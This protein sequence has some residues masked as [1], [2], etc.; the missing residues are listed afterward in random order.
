MAT[1]KQSKRNAKHISHLLNVECSV[2]GG[3][4]DSDED[5]DVEESSDD[6]DGFVV[7]KQRGRPNVKGNSSTSV[8]DS[9]EALSLT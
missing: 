3:N 5:F 1:G 4:D 2:A 6:D 8:D 7:K 9:L